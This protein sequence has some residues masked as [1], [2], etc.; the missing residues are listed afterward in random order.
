MHI[1]HLLLPLLA[2]IQLYLFA[3]PS[4]NI[5]YKQTTYVNTERIPAEWASQV[6]KEVENFYVLTFN[7]SASLYF[8]NPDIKNE[9][10][11]FEANDSRARMMRRFAERTDKIYYKNLDEGSVLEQLYFF[12][13]AFLV[14]DTVQIF[15][16]KIAAGEQK[17]ILGYT[18]MKA[19]YKDSTENLVVYFTPQI[20]VPYGPDRFGELPGAI[21][22]IQSARNHWMATSVVMSEQ[23]LP[24]I[25]PDKGEK[26][27]KAAFNKLREEKMKEQRE[28]WGGNRRGMGF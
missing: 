22:E 7:S 15:K 5:Y 18:C 4:G 6:P 27:T 9:L 26:M 25:P 13:K 8:K 20:S 21:L 19:I 24:V 16:W 3:Q 14:S 10:P 17:E 12:N 11:E 28:M 1:R 23:Q 2:L